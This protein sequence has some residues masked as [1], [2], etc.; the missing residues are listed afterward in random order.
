MTF[1]T[2]AEPVLASLPHARRVEPAV[3]RFNSVPA[4]GRSLERLLRELGWAIEAKQLAARFFL[5]LGG[6]V[7]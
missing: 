3:Q 2:D 7:G 5:R 6:R 1:G 4:V